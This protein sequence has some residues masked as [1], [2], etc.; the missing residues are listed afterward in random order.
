MIVEDFCDQRVLLL[1]E[2]S[3]LIKKAFRFAALD[4]PD[5]CIAHSWVDVI[6]VLMQ[7][8]SQG[9]R[10]NRVLPVPIAPLRLA[11]THEDGPPTPERD[12]VAVHTICQRPPSCPP[13]AVAPRAI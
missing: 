3:Q 2:S 9:A 8:F 6:E 10:E 12:A 4:R 7:V 5:D 13:T 1:G 11:R